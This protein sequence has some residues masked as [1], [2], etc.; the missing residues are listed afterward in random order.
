MKVY[1]FMRKQSLPI[2]I[3]QAWDFFSVPENLVRITPGYMRFR[4]LHRTGGPSIYA[5]QI[6]KYR[7]FVFPLLPVSWTTEITH[8]Q[9]PN[10][11][12][13]E[14]RLGPYAFWHHQHH[15]KAVA[16]GV[17]MTDQVTYALPLGF[18]G[19]I[20]NWLFVQRQLNAIFDYRFSVLKEIFNKDQII[21]TTT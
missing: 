7:L 19:Q 13:D 17:E 11:F 4:I 3:E 6:I 12:V 14:Q 2:T 16:D 5:G 8:V 20:A 21:L 18:L 15:F 9:K 10:D 1:T